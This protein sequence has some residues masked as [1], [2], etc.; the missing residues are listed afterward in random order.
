MP[1]NATSRAGRWL[2]ALLALA[3]GAA[4]AAPARAQT[5]APASAAS[6]PAVPA[7]NY[8]GV[9]R[10]SEVE[11]SPDDRHVAFL[12]I[13]ERGRRVLAVSELA[14]PGNA[15]IVA[16]LADG[17][18]RAVN[19]VNE[20]RLIY[21]AQKTGLVIEQGEGGIFAVDLD[22]GRL[23][24]LVAWVYDLGR[25][26]TRFKEK[27]LPYG[28]FFH[29]SLRGRG[30]EVLMH[31]RNTRSVDDRSIVAFGR[32]DTATGQLTRVD[33]G[34]PSGAVRHVFDRDGE[35]R[36]VSTVSE[37]RQRVFH[38]PADR[39]AWT[40]IEDL[41][42]T[43]DGHL[44]P[45]YIERNGSWVVR[46]SRG[47]DTAGLYSYDP[48]K[49][50]LL[51]EPLVAVDGFDVSGGIGADWRQQL[52][53]SVWVQAD[54]WQRVWFDEKMAAV[55]QEV[56]ASLPKGRVNGL[57]CGDCATATRFVV[58]SG[59]DRVPAEY[60]VYDREARKLALIG[61]SHPWLAESSQGRRSFHRVA[62][63]DGLT[64]PVV[65]THPARR[66]AGE[67]A[68]T[69]VYVHGGPW[70]RGADTSWSEEPQFLAAHG[71]RVLEVEFRG[72][73]GFGQKHFRAGWRQWG[74]A[75][76]DDLVDALDWAVKNKLADP[77]RVCIVGGSYG[78]YAALMGPVRH[79]GR[80]RCA[81]SFAGVTDLSKLFSSF[82]TDIPQHAQRFSLPEL[83]GDESADA[84]MLRRHSPIHRV[85]EIKVPL[86]LAHGL[87]DRRV[88]VA[89]TE[90]FAAAAR[91]AGLPVELMTFSN[92]GHGFYSTRNHVRYL[93]ALAVFLQ[94]HLGGPA[95]KR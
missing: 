20:K 37:G 16:A 84:E 81:A 70:V 2:P 30:D 46:T 68:P 60:F 63:R 33:A 22:G 93:E 59:S 50:Q 86:F 65:V 61:P 1:M 27:L 82:W 28:W 41:P 35:L 88:D 14:A 36:I 17:D 11:V 24:H 54:R 72:S 23:Q 83:L 29:A 67:P 13:D 42:V 43:D 45:L 58:K 77:G 53:S 73:L 4:V 87:E 32:L 15:R 10:I 56:D 76:Q 64:L 38:R 25:S 71:W 89:H 55:Q 9:P 3:L 44:E 19:W 66:P 8:V 92:E 69:V 78:G 18:I 90:R 49:R 47:R 52:I 48:A 34:M 57:S 21:T 91:D 74:Q 26:G 5:A 39:D 31:Q 6:A 94:R 7:L 85:A 80:Y 62:A 12:P 75:M 51:P 95:P 79:P 40:P